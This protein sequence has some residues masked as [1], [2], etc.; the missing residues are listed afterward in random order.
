MSEPEMDAPA[1]RRDLEFWGGALNKRIDAVDA[2]ID[3]VSSR[4]DQAVVAIT[5]DIVMQVKA[6]LQVLRDEVMGELHSQTHGS[7]KETGF[8]R[9]GA[10]ETARR[11]SSIASRFADPASTIRNR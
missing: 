9:T 11:A 7:A 5:H 10:C 8:G 3:V 4:I 2:R 1:T 6:L